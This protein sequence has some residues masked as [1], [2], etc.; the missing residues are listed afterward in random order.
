MKVLLSLKSLRN[1]R[2]FS[3]FSRGS[4]GCIKNEQAFRRLQGVC[5]DQAQHIEK[6]FPNAGPSFL[7]QMLYNCQKVAVKDKFFY[8]ALLNRIET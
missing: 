1:T 3:F 6:L 7:L 2:S 4:G 8:D 5:E